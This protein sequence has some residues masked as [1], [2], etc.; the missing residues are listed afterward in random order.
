MSEFQ[1]KVIWETHCYRIVWIHKQAGAL[2][3]DFVIEFQGKDALGNF[4][5][6]RAAHAFEAEHVARMIGEEVLKR[7]IKNV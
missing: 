2:A 3:D 4:A 7:G 6:H 1:P 5:W